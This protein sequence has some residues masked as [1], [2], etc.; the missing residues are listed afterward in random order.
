M[1]KMLSTPA[2]WL[3]FNISSYLGIYY[4][5]IIFSLELTESVGKSFL[6]GNF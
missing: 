5:T 3:E 2:P 1:W 4:L 6:G